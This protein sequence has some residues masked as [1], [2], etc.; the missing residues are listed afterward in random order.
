MHVVHTAAVPPNHGRM[1]LLTSGCTWK[2]KK[3]LTKIV[4]AKFTASQTLREDAFIK[5]AFC[6]A[7]VSFGVQLFP[8]RP[9]TLT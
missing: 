4:A 7:I 5:A 8:M 9:P 3:A 2:S 6:N 1:A